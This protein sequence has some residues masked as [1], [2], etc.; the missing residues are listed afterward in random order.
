MDSTSHGEKKKSNQI[1]KNISFAALTVGLGLLVYY[2]LPDELS[3]NA[4]LLAGLFVGALV[5]WATELL[6]IAVTSLLILAVGPVLGIFGSLSEAVVGFTNP[7]VYF[8]IA[9]FIISMAFQQSGLARR[10]ALWLIS[11]SGTDAKRIILVFMMGCA[12]NASIMSNVPAA[13]IWMSLTLPILKNLGVKKGK[14]N[15]AKAIMI[16]IPIAS[17]TGGIMTPAGSST[18]VLALS[19]L[20]ELKGIE[21]PFVNWMALGVPLGLIMTVVSWWVLVRVFRP[22]IQQIGEIKEFT[23]EREANKKWKVIEIKATVLIFAMVSLWVLSS[24]V[25]GLNI[26]IIAIIGSCIMFL[27]GINLLNWRE[28]RNGIGWDSVLIVGSVTT[29]GIA[30]TQNGLSDWVVSNMLGGIGGLPL[31]WALLVICLFTIVLHLP[32]PVIPTIIS[33]IVPAMVVLAV[34]AG[35]NPAIYALAVAFASHCAFLL[36]LDPVPLV[37]Y[38][39]GYYRMFDMFYPGSIISIIWAVVNAVILYFIGPLVGM[40]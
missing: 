12:V 15:F 2:I 28:T 36:P 19:L 32:I 35:V 7:V 8:I 21:I 34:N 17:L 33:A 38:S 30:S 29:L 20:Q 13:A 18:N 3:E 24:W 9:S 25:S 22:E 26:T 1:I 23:E 39:K 10:V 31:F 5:L 27:P 37:T 16:G 4:R 40:V 14:S 6:P 11:R